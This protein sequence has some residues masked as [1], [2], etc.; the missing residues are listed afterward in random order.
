MTPAD[1]SLLQNT[2]S[3]TRATWTAG[4]NP[5][6]DL[7]HAERILRLGAVHPD[8]LAGLQA[9]E[10]RPAAATIAP[11]A[12]L[13]TSIDWRAY[14]GHNYISCVKDQGNCGSCV[15]FGSSA[16]IDGAM[17]F[18]DNAPLWTTKGNTLQDVSE[19]QLYYCSKTPSDGHNCA[20]GWWPDSAFAYAEHTGLAPASCF[21]YTAGDQPCKLCADSEQK[22]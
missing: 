17:R 7:T 8:G 16:T 2:L 21:P 18:I 14:N 5:L 15:A 10:A 4:H 3:Q 12:S 20:T 11:Q 22:S 19:A 13:P 1:L 6:L 9:R